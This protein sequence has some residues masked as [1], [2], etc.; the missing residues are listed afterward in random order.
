MK[1]FFS[2][3]LSQVI[4]SNFIKISQCEYSERVMIF[5]INNYKQ[6]K[7]FTV[8]T[9]IRRVYLNE[10]NLLLSVT[11]IPMNCELIQNL[12]NKLMSQ[13]PIKNSSL[14]AL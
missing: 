2:K 13:V 11:S 5:T 14:F 8:Q 6:K 3:Y 12:L 9:I 10:I 4:K 7:I 1:H